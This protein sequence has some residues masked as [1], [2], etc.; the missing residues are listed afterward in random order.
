MRWAS[1]KAVNGHSRVPTPGIAWALWPDRGELL[2]V[3]EQESGLW[4]P[5][6]ISPAMSGGAWGLAE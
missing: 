4:P 1:M 6:S 3:H 2:K 5:G